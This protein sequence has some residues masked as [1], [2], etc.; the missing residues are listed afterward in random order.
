VNKIIPKHIDLLMR[1]GDNPNPQLNTIEKLIAQDAYNRVLSSSQFQELGFKTTYNLFHLF[2]F[3]MNRD[4]YIVKLLYEA[5]PYPNYI[6]MEA[7][8]GYCQLNCIMCEKEYWNEKPQMLSFKNFKYAMDQFPDLKWA[9]NNGLG[10]PFLNP[11]YRQMVK[12]LDDKHVCQ[13]IYLTSKAFEKGDIE[14]FVDYNSFIFLKFSFDAATK[15]TYE[16]IRINGDY[17]KVIDNII[18]FDREKKRRGKHYPELQFHF[19]VM[20][21]NI[22]ECEQYVKLIHD[23]G[24]DC[25]N[26]TFSRMLH[27]FKQTEHLYT[28][29]PDTLMKN[30]EIAGKRYG[31][32]VT[33][34]ADAAG[35][36]PPINL[37]TAWTMPYIFPDGTVIS[38]CCMNMQNRRDW[39]RQTAMGNI[40]QTPMRDIWYGPKYKLLRKK[41]YEMKPLEA[42]PVCEICN[43]YDVNKCCQI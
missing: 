6:E 27:K 42:H 9:G 4:P 37:C 43:I 3:F 10:D 38:C 28:D 40:F 2:R 36:K 23:L 18:R 16:S 11:E 32:P 24:V 1:G 26:I 29:I 8:Q 17:D 19:V 12:Y 33:F 21:N 22:H 15:D 5:E 39:Q 14:K 35:T 7:I 30:L 31:I 34:N 13:E 25:S 20:K 41:L